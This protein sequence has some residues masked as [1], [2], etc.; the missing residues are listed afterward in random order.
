MIETLLLL[1][2]VSGFGVFIALQVRER[3]RHEG[4]PP[5]R[6]ADRATEAGR[7]EAEAWAR[8]RDHGGGVGGGSV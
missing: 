1:V 5:D 6:G 4:A 3:R 2:L 7:A 8:S